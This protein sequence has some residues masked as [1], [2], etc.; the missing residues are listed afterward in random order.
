MPAGQHT[1]LD[2]STTLIITD[3]VTV[4]DQG[5]GVCYV[6]LQLDS[7]GVPIKENCNDEELTSLSWLQSTDLLQSINICIDLLFIKDQHFFY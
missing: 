4:G 6:H 2:D 3:S 7:K 5:S 1:L